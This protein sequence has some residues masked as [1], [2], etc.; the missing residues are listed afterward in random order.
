MGL[1]SGLDP[2]QP[3]LQFPLLDLVD[4]G[5]SLAFVGCHVFHR[6]H[7]PLVHSGQMLQPL[8][9]GKQFPAEFQLAVLL[10]IARIGFELLAGKVVAGFPL[11]ETKKAV[12]LMNF[13]LMTEILCLFELLLPTPG[14]LL[15][16]SDVR[17]NFAS[18]LL[19]VEY[20]EVLRFMIHLFHNRWGGLEGMQ[21]E[22]RRGF[23]P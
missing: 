12:L 14:T 16:L 18:F 15:F 20:R 11:S 19:R 1:Q 23:E 21:R 7:F 5:Q 6:V 13:L 22:F 8:H 2:L 9:R 10:P 3:R 17:M 4:F